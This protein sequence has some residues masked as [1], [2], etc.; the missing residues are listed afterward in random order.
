MPLLICS[1]HRS[2]SE[3]EVKERCNISPTTTIHLIHDDDRDFSEMTS[4]MNSDASNDMDLVK[5]HD[6]MCV[7]CLNFPFNP[8]LSFQWER[9]AATCWTQSPRMR[10]TQSQSLVRWTSSAKTE[11]LC[12]SLSPKRT[13]SP[14]G[15]ASP[16]SSCGLGWGW[17]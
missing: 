4:S 13:L 10:K 9:P 5:H 2:Y 6:G 14:P 12:R 11:G 17:G 3:L 7:L 8:L 15:S 1:S 16:G